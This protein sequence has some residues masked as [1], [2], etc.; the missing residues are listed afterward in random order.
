MLSTGVVHLSVTSPSFM[1]PTSSSPSPPFHLSHLELDVDDDIDHLLLTKFFAGSSET[2]TTLTVDNLGESPSASSSIITIL[3]HIPF[4]NLR[5]ITIRNGRYKAYSN[6][7][8]VLSAL[9]SLTFIRGT[10]PVDF[11]STIASTCSPTLL[12][13]NL[14]EQGKTGNINFPD[15]CEALA[16]PGFQNLRQLYLPGLVPSLQANAFLV[17]D[18]G[19]QG[20]RG[21]GGGRGELAGVFGS[22]RA[23]VYPT[24][25]WARTLVL[26]VRGF[27]F[28]AVL[29]SHALTLIADFQFN[30]G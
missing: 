15:L 9:Q 23:E 16:L 10:A 13:L 19:R 26:R 18:R 1:H 8:P 27:Y 12:A 17:A 24:S 29:A 11:F 30:S 21:A 20:R 5:H 6:L 7:L 3:S 4:P 25:I 28:I 14:Q 22:V 2:L